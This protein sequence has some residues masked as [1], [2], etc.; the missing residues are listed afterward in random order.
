MYIYFENPPIYKRNGTKRAKK[1]NCVS[2]P[3]R[4]HDIFFEICRASAVISGWFCSSSVG[5]GTWAQEH[6]SNVHCLMTFFWIFVL[7][8]QQFGGSGHMGTRAPIQCALLNDIFLNICLGFAAVRWVS[9]VGLGTWAQE[10][11]S[12]VHCFFYLIRLTIIWS[13][14]IHQY[15][16]AMAPKGQKKIGVSSPLTAVKPYRNIYT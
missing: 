10:H 15:T 13:I 6:Q 3:L 4:T 8:L 14:S 7:V 11:Q 1:K 5:L 16:K 9:S 12:N 2:S